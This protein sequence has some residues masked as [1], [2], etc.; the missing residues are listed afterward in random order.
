MLSDEEVAP[1][2]WWSVGGKALAMLG[3]LEPKRRI[4]LGSET[5]RILRDPASS[6]QDRR[7]AESYT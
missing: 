5:Q 4:H 1:C 6:P 7:W 3:K 2:N